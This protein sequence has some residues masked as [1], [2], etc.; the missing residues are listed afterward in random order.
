MELSIPIER[1]RELESEFLRRQPWM[2]PYQLA[3]DVIVGRF[4]EH[5]IVETCC[6]STSEPALKA[7]MQKAFADYMEGDPYHHMDELI[8]RL[9]GDLSTSSVLD[10]ACATGRF[11]FYLALNGARRVRG[12]EIRQEQVDQAELLR[13]EDDRFGGLDL[14]FECEPMSADDPAFLAGE[15]FDVTLS[16]GLLY[17][18][19]NPLQHLQNLARIT[20]RATLVFTMTHAARP[21]SWL[22]FPEDPAGMTKGV[23][24]ISW[25][26]HYAEV[27]KLLRQCGF[28]RVEIPVHPLVVPFQERQAR[29]A[30]EGGSVRLLS[31]IADELRQTVA[32]RREAPHLPALLAHAQN[33]R[34]FAYLAFKD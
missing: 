23:G 2:H 24:G 32:A 22:M 34:Y 14:A 1:V 15:K 7:G 28:S 21:A 31:R 12:I 26:P 6:V 29:A 16:M 18:L 8:R 10:I 33:P 9:N 27:P 30:L 3:D 13:R 20:R 4:K 5:R 17:H 19:V 25:V 11:S